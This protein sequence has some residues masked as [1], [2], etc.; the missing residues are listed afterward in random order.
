MQYWRVHRP[1]TAS[2]P[3]RRRHAPTDDR[4]PSAAAAPVRR[5]RRLTAVPTG[6]LGAYPAGHY[7]PRINRHFTSACIQLCASDSSCRWRARPVSGETTHGTDYQ[8]ASRDSRRISNALS[9]A[10]HVQPTPQPSP[11]KRAAV[12][13]LSGAGAHLNQYSMAVGCFLSSSDS[14]NHTN[15]M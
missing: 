7:R 5:H 4:P 12:R 15:S 10:S 2:L 14:R 11:E 9:S 1:P 3:T 13:T 8:S 6:T